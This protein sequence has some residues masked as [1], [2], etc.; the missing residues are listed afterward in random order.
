MVYLVTLSHITY[1]FPSCRVD[2]GECLATDR[3]HKPVVDENLG[4]K[5][6]TFTILIQSHFCLSYASSYR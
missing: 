6:L 3:V 2:C 4:N 5:D 1:F